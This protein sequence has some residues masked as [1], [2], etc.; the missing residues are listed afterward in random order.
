VEDHSAAVWAILMKGRIG[1][2]YLIGADEEM[3]NKDVLELM[4]QPKD[5]YDYVKDRAGHD[6]RYGI[7]SAKL[8][9]EL[10]WTPQ[11]TDFR[12]G[13]ADTIKWYTENKDWWEAEKES[14]EANYAKNNQ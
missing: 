10:G 4:G 11:F 3:N 7:D 13:L 6:L 12:D 5:A 2:T 1:E 9:D 14:V 8:S